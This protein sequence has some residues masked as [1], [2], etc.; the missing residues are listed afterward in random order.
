[1]NNDLE[2]KLQG[3]KQIYLKKLET[4]LSE[5][6]ALFDSEQTDI[7]ELYSRV[8]TISG[9]SGMY[10]LKQISEI[11]TEFEIYLKKI[12]EALQAGMGS[13]NFNELRDKFSQY[14]SNLEK[15]ILKGE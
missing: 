15:G 4:V 9:T 11:S 6:K 14:L 7:N 5:L 2:N 8:H 3:L 10:G 1:M 13:I 12:K